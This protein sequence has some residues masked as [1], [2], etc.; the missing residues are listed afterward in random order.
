M[1]RVTKTPIPTSQQYQANGRMAVTS[2]VLNHRM[3]A[4]TLMYAAIPAAT[5]TPYHQ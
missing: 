4:Q 5:P 3:S 2:L 1:K